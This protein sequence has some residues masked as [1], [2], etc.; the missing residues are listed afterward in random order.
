MRRN[1][2]PIIQP[3]YNKNIPTYLGQKGYTIHKEHLTQD[4][5]KTLKESLI[6]RPSVMG[7]M[8]HVDNHFPIFRESAKKLYIPRY[9]GELH[10]GI[11]KEIKIPEGDDINID[12]HGELRP[13]QIPAVAAYMKH[14]KA[15]HAAGLLELSC[16]AGKCLGYN[17]PILMYDGTIKMVQDVVVGDVLMGDDSQPRNVGSLARGIDHLFRITDSYTGESYIVNR[18]HILS[19]KWIQ[20]HYDVKCGDV[21]DISLFDYIQ[22]PKIYRGPLTPLYGFRVPITFPPKEDFIFDPYFVGYWLGN[23]TLPFT[24]EITNTKTLIYITCL[25][26]SKYPSLHLEHHVRDGCIYHIRNE[27]DTNVFDSFLDSQGIKV[28]R[29]IPDSMKIN[30]PQNQLK[31]LAGILDSKMATTS[32]GLENRH[33]YVVKEPCGGLILDDICFL[34]RS[35]GFS[36]RRYNS[37]TLWITGDLEKIPVL[38]N[39]KKGKSLPHHLHLT[40]PLKIQKLEHGEYYGFTI[41]GN[42]RFVLGDFTVTHNTVMSLNIISQIQKKTL[43]IVNKEFLLNQWIER[44]QEFLPSARVGRIQGPIIDIEN[45]DIVIGMLQSLSMKD[46]PSTVFS[47]FGLT[48]LDEVHHISSEVFSSALFKIVTKYMLGLSA[49]MERKDGTTY[50]IKMFL[51]DVVYKGEKDDSHDV[52]VRAI[53]YRTRDQEFQDVEYDYRGNPQYSKMITKLCEYAPR[54]NFIVGVVADLIEANPT[55]QIMI[56]GHNRS[57][58][59]Y[60][61]DAISCRGFAT[62]GYY[63]GGMKQS[64]LQETETKQIVI[65]TYSMAAEALDIKTLTTLVM[66]TPK[67]DIVQ[68]VGRI[69]RT[70]HTQPIIVD[71][72]DTHQ[73]FQNQWHKRRAYYKKCNYKI[74]ITD[75]NSY[76]GTQTIWKNI[77][78]P[79]CHID[80]ASTPTP[81]PTCL[82]DTS[83]FA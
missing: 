34:A 75:S 79:K 78:E 77:F 10:F 50:V 63:V 19:L 15:T 74:T 83:L 35:L 66:V 64:A 28:D 53:E 69:L 11:P 12:F 38:W 8:I 58:L 22:L 52:L 67:T 37:T 82:I 72:I 56:L 59:T 54:S 73:L 30:S 81:T 27:T 40:Y 1:Q 23:R 48:I 76:D 24:I 46:Y 21:L 36:V 31:I 60:L 57:L 55:C 42:R 4:E 32:I 29:R 2:P 45:R 44:I 70:K 20:N 47:S 5:I 71:I 25:F 6:A 13:H 3:C 51:G 43:I 26:R 18:R 14:V 7:G 80:D 33:K 62:T 17:T 68:S 61:H 65:A 9:Y 41:D 16:A 49:T 39:K